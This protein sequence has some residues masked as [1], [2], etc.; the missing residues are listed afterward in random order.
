M[1]FGSCGSI[2]SPEVAAGVPF[3]YGRAPLTPPQ[4]F[5]LGEGGFC[6]GS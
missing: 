1:C 2:T 6:V 3:N 5:V 4:I